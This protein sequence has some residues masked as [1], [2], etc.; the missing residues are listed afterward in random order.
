M[1]DNSRDGCDLSSLCAMLSSSAIALA[2]SLAHVQISSAN[3]A[4]VSILAAPRFFLDGP[5]LDPIR[6]ARIAIVRSRREDLIRAATSSMDVAA[7]LPL[8]KGPPRLPLL[9]VVR[10]IEWIDWS[11]G[12]LLNFRWLHNW[13]CTAQPPP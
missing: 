10:A 9:V 7:P 12:L 8:V 3:A 1:G 6:E 11:D 13:P 2:C 4:L 5:S